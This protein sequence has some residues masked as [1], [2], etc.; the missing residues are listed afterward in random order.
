[1]RKATVR[2]PPHRARTV[3]DRAAPI[4]EQF[5]ETGLDYSRDLVHGP[6]LLRA[7]GRVKGLRVLDVGCG[8]GRFTRRLAAAGALVTA[9]D[10]SGP[11]IELA[12]AREAARPLGIDYQVRDARTIG[13]ELLGG[14]FDLAVGC[15][16]FMDMPDLP[17]V[18]RSI[19]RVL[20]P[21][22]R[23]V[24]SV[25]H[26]LN[27]ASAGRA[28]PKAR[29]Q[30]GMIVDR[31]FDRRV[32]TTRWR[33]AR[34]PAPFDTLTWHRSLE[35]WFRLLQAS[36]FTVEG[37]SEPHATEAQARRVPLLRATRRFPFFLVVGCRR[38]RDRLRARSVHGKRP[39]RG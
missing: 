30:G 38:D 14:R 2:G 33:M 16:S 13:P 17:K 18:L 35:D 5:Q 26:P 36:G 19:R 39:L 31:Y 32:E 37:L 27:S 12:R 22:G 4:W 23:L 9:I 21:G 25:V 6:G 3:W 34:L 15:M 28:R 11:M 1:M 8:Q 24:F 10:W 29:D 20:R 7:I